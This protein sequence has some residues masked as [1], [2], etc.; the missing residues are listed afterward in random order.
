M[1]MALVGRCGR[2]DRRLHNLHPITVK[3]FLRPALQLLPIIGAMGGLLWLLGGIGWS[4]IAEGVRRVGGAGAA[5]LCALALAETVLDSAALCA[6]V[7]ARLRLAFA[8]AVN[9]AG[10]M[11]N[12]LLPWDSGEVLKSALLRGP[13]GAQRAVSGTILWNY[14]Y[15]LSRPA[16]SALAAGLA[17]ALCR[18]GTGILTVVVAAS[19]LAFVPYLVLRVLVSYGAAQ[20]VTRLVGLLPGLRRRSQHWLELAR[21]ID[22]EVRQFWQDRRRDY[23]RAFAYQAAARAT[24]WLA[25]YVGFLVMG[26]P[27]GFAEATLVYAVMNVAEYALA[28]LPAR[29]GVTEGAAFLAFKALGLDPTL[30]VVLYVVLRVRTMVVNGV[31]TPLAFVGRRAETRRAAAHHLPAPIDTHKCTI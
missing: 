15:K 12:L 17:W 23:L 10:S 14:I 18:Q 29:I 2:L 4:T 20:G 19:A 5:L 22:R 28:L 7:G 27:Y 6:T 21:S 13:F 31:L 24:A 16:V 26:L 1:A 25:V 9:A 30:G 3:R 11:L 8:V